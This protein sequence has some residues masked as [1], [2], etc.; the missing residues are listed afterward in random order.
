[1]ALA[2]KLAFLRFVTKT[3]DAMGMNMISKGVEKALSGKAFLISRP[4]RPFS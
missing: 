4:W 3:G 1:M 2:G